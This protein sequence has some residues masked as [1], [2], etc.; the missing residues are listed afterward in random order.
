M[1]DRFA[2][3]EVTVITGASGWLG[4]ALVHRFLHDPTRH[5]LRLLAATAEEGHHLAGFGD[6][7]VVIGDVTKPDTAARLLHGVGV[8]ADLIH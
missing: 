1:V 2:A 4:R 8:D 5:R 6:V 7:E 3:P